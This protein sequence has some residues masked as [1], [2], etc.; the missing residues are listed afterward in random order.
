MIIILFNPQIPQNTGNIIRTCFLTN[1]DLYLVKPLGFSLSKRQL[2]RSGI[3]YFD[4]QKINVLD[5]L[6]DFLLDKEDFYFF[7]SKAEKK[8]T[9]VKYTKDSILIFGSETFGLPEK[10][11]KKMKEKFVTIPMK[12]DSRCLNLS[13]SV[14]IGLYE[15]FR[16][17]NFIF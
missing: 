11:T 10:Y 4:E 8:Y 13:N 3:D 12:K 9:D 6:D 1:S 14:A 15:C 5:N 16:Q 2:R 7:S 17:N